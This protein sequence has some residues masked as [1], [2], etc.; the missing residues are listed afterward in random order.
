MSTSNSTAALRKAQRETAFS[1]FEVLYRHTLAARQAASAFYDR[2]P[3]EINAAFFDNPAIAAYESALETSLKA[4]AQALSPELAEV[5]DYML[6][7]PLEMTVQNSPEEV[8]LEIAGVEEFVQYMRAV[9]VYEVPFKKAKT[10]PGA[11]AK[12]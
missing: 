9:Y 2:I 4:A 6:E 11:S 5:L 1:I 10:R 12:K 8:P 7:E 3:R